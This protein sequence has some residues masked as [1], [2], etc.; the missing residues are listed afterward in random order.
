MEV[1]LL[2]STAGGWQIL[3]FDFDKLHFLPEEG[4]SILCPT[5]EV[6]IE[7]N[8]STTKRLVRTVLV[9]FLCVC[10]TLVH[11]YYVSISANI[12]PVPPE[13]YAH[14]TK[15]RIPECRIQLVYYV[16]IKNINF[17]IPY[18]TVMVGNVKSF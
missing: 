6:R 7:S 9:R 2:P 18:L 16:V 1:F 17:V 4:D 11:I 13:L 10:H 12:C 3:G 15:T 5:S 8:S 14:R